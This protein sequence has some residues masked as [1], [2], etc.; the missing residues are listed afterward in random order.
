MGTWKY[1]EPGVAFTSESTL[2]EAGGE[3]VAETCKN[4][5]ESTYSSLG[6]SSSNTYF[7]FSDD[8]TFSAK[9]LG[10]SCSGKYTFDEDEQAITL[11]LTI[12]KITGYTKKSTDGISLLFESKKILT[13]L[14]AVASISGN[15]ALSTISE[16]STNYDGVRIGFDLKK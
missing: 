15:Q 10:K 7:T 5:L 9:I 2:A 3:V 8:G 6:F 16:L 11:N 4:K 12:L 13:L 1:D 14:Q